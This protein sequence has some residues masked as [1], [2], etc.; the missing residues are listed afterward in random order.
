MSPAAIEKLAGD[1]MTT[2]IRLWRRHFIELTESLYRLRGQTPPPVGDAFEGGWQTTLQWHG[3][4]FR[5]LHDD[6]DDA[7]G[8][9]ALQ[10]AFCT[11][12]QEAPADELMRA[13]LEM[14]HVLARQAAGMFVFDTDTR[15]LIY[16]LLSP[17][18]GATASGVLGTMEG[19]IP[20]VDHWRATMPRVMCH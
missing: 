7:I 11:V 17:L 8:R 15:E 6:P 5:L 19:L 18:Q 12:P 13:A 3:V 9:F 2:E 16:S 10:C 1:T 4:G 14:N 20:L